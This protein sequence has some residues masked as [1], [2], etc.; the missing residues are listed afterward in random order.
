MSL[1]GRKRRYSKT[2][3]K[4]HFQSFTH[5]AGLE[6]TSVPPEE[7]LTLPTKPGAYMSDSSVILEPNNK[8]RMAGDNNLMIRAST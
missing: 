7:F 6:A 4:N 5:S 2:R 8:P 1:T 3:T